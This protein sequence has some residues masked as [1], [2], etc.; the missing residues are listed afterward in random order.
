MSFYNSGYKKEEIEEAA[1]TL[2]QRRQGEKRQLQD[3]K[4]SEK[5]APKKGRAPLKPKAKKQSIA[6][7]PRK[8]L[9]SLLKFKPRSQEVS[10]YEIKQKPNI[11]III[12]FVALLIILLGILITIILFKE[13]IVS[14]FSNLF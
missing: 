4:E 14:F 6:K 11:V 12:L 7:K 13:D 5:Q 8:T 9:K 3:K 10:Q 1:R 2:M